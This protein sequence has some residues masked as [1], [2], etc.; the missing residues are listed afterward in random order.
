YR[1]DQTVKLGATEEWIVRN[2]S[3]HWHPFHIHVNDFQVVAVKGKKV[4]RVSNG[5]VRD[6]PAGA[7]ELEDTVKLPPG[8]TVTMRTRPTDFTGKFVFHCHML[9]HEDRGMMG[10]V[11]VEAP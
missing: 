5:P 8:A 9:D 10:V 6:V 4:P 7:V 2:T 11:E 3:S 1:I